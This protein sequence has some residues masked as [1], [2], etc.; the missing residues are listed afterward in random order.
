MDD[1]LTTDEIRQFLEQLSRHYSQSTILYLL[2]GGALCFLGNPRHT[3]DID[4]SVINPP[5]GFEATI[6][7]V[8]NE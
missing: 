4:C 1:S 2:G 5:K 7:E 6:E 3:V 8:S